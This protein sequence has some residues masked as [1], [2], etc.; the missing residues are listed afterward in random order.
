MMIPLLVGVGPVLPRAVLLVAAKVVH[1][2]ARLRRIVEHYVSRYL[3]VGWSQQ[4][5]AAAKMLES[6]EAEVI[7]MESRAQLPGRLESITD[8]VRRP[9]SAPVGRH[10]PR[11]LRRGGPRSGEE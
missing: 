4:L 10:R 6:G 11:R 1:D 3:I 5:S 7:V 8:G 2:E 9:L